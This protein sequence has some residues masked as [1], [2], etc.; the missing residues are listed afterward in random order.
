MSNIRPKITTTE[1]GR[2]QEQA[3]CEFLSMKGL[4]LVA[5]N[6]RSKAGEIDL[7]MTDTT[8]EE[9]ELVFIEVRSKAN[10]EYGHAFETIT[11]SKQYKLKKTATCYL[12]EKALY[13]TI[14]CRFD[15]IAIHDCG[16][17]EP[18]EW[19]KNAIQ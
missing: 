19:I 7:I 5:R 13:N 1:K 2:K 16:T 8:L 15:I 9:P 17:V 14:P 4:R 12:I 3:A 10:P 18:I 11:R 6:Y